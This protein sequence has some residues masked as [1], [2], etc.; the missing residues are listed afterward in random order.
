MANK[1]LGIVNIEPSYVK[2]E[3]IED[4]RP[5]SAA[6]IFGRYRVIDFI[7]SNLT[8]SGIYNIDVQ[9][10][11]RPRSTIQHLNRTNYNIN[12]KKG[13]I[14]ILHGEKPIS[15]EIYNTD[16]ASLMANLEFFEESN[17]AYVVLCPSHFVYAMDMMEL[18]EHHI[19][20]KN[21]ITVL[22]QNVSDADKNFLMCD[23]LDFNKSKRITKMEK[24]LG[25]SKSAKIS[26]ET[27][28]MSMKTFIDSLYAAKTISSLYSLSDIIAESINDFKVGAYHH[29]GYAAC[30]SNLNAYY[31][32]NMDIKDEKELH[33]MINDDW[34]IYT[35]TSD[36][37]PTLYTEGAKVT[38]S[39]I[40][41][42]CLIEGTV[43]NS[44]IGRNV[45]IKKGSVIKDCV[46][47]PD[48]LIN[49]NVTM[50]KVV[51]DRLAIVTHKKDL[52][53]SADMPLYVN[54]RDRI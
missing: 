5:I 1:V 9:V 24:N 50:E 12:T 4:Y 49:K 43:I 32:A 51:V 36:S 42:G 16:I 35:A 44:V 41:N 7:L 37:C 30:I 11:N 48:A 13:K 38:S 28:V 52:K 17:A 21:D 20:S 8:N 53:G 39:I 18:V 54:R 14:R 45:V 22:Y 26:L 34:P 29:H 27:Y 15:N 10:K 46:V 3:G 25:K 6:S 33:K 2:V 19:K 47:M 40:G 31:K 23:T